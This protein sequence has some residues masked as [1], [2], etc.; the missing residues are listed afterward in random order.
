MSAPELATAVPEGL[1]V[2]AILVNDRRLSLIK[3]I[4]ERRYAGR[5]LGVD[6][7]NPDF[8]KLAEAFGV[9]CWRPASDLEFEAALGEAVDQKRPALIEV[10]VGRS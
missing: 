10:R 7:V 3:A 4:Q 5:F 8:G 2:V 6:L 9:R 1:A